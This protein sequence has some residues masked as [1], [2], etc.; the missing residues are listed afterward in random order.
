MMLN[1][2]FT[3][4]AYR[5]TDFVRLGVKQIQRLS[6]DSPIL[7]SDDRSEE[8]E[9][10]GRIADEHG[11]NY[12]CSKIRRGHFSAD[13][14]SMVSSL[15]FAQS[16]GADVAVKISQRTILRKPEAIDVIQKVFADSN[17]CA[18]TP[19]RPEKI[20][21]GRAAHGFKAFSILSDI[22]MIRVGCMS[23]QDLL[24]MYRER[25]LRERLPWSSF[26]ECAVD[27]L[28]NRK[29]PGRTAKIEELTNP[30]PDPIYLR[31]YQATER[32]YR[33]LAITHGIN[34]RYPCE[35]WGALER[36]KYLCKPVVV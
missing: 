4:G 9:H 6:P 8:S 7:I 22:V 33:E 24:V 25:L 19:G 16:A 5:L 31:R 3:I 14:Q 15:A 17:I 18:A 1:L 26:I 30:T 20:I 10:M 21:G 23:A 35:E 12:K 32:D 2:A 34:G 28:H 27:D 29:F 13:F 36:N 11:V